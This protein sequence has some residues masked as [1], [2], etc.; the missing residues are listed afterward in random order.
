MSVS[1]DKPTVFFEDFQSNDGNEKASYSGQVDLARSSG[2][3]INDALF[4]ANFTPEERNRL[5]RKVRISYC[6]TY[7]TRMLTDDRLTSD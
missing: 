1:S 2:L 7:A 5:L 6:V 4:Y 3:S